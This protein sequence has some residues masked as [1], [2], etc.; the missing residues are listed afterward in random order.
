MVGV[1]KGGGRYF[2]DVEESDRSEG[3]MVVVIEGDEA[4]CGTAMEVTT[5]WGVC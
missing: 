2:V 4:W 1:C 3:V 5:G